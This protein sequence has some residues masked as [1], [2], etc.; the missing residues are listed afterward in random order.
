MRFNAVGRRT[1]SAVLPVD[2]APLAALARASAACSRSLAVQALVAEAVAVGDP[3]L[4]DR[5]VLARHHAHHPV[6]PHLHD[7]GWRRRRRAGDAVLLASAPRCAR[8]SGTACAVSA[9]TGQRSIMLPDSSES[10]RCARCTVPISHVL[11][12]AGRTEFHHAGD[13][14][15]EAH[16]ARA[17]DAARHLLG[18]DQR[19]DVL[20]AARR[21][22]PRCSARRRRRS[23]R[24]G[25]AAGT[26]RPGRRSGSPAGG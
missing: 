24:P 17:V 5:L 20:V 22:C 1:R 12:A 11:A 23:P 16:A 18:R 13:L 7:A 9:P 4:V 3:A 6:A 10:T 25:P 14:L 2:L 21:A 26:R 15:A 19:A 8:C